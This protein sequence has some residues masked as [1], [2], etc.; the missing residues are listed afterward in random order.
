MGI[1]IDTIA[2][3]VMYGVSAN[4]QIATTPVVTVYVYTV[5]PGIVDDVI[6]YGA[7]ES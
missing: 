6:A 5:A 3:Q 2:C 7:V 1:K 4:K